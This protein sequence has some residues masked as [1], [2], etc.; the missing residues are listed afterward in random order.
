MG[1]HNLPELGPMLLPG[2]N[3]YGVEFIDLGRKAA[4]THAHTLDIAYGPDPF[5]AL[6]VWHA[7]ALDGPK[8][9]VVVFIHGGAFR[10]G[11]KEWIGAMAPAITALPAVLVSFNYRLVPRVTVSSI[12]DDCFE[13][14][15]W[16]HNNIALF[17]GD[18]SRIF[19]G[20]HSA[21]AFLAAMLVLRKDELTRRSILHESI[22]A[23]MPLSGLFSL[24]REDNSKDSIVARFWQEM[25]EDD[26]TA[27]ANSAVTY[28]LANKTPFYIAY[29]EDE[30]DEILNANAKMIERSRNI[31]LTD[32]WFIRKKGVQKNA[33]SATSMMQITM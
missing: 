28:A 2:A 27:E 6:D 12:V 8:L 15:A 21:G 19:I 26:A 31:S 24:R 4:E 11:H 9:P 13:A 30:P 17:G 23:C 25:V 14:L 5:Q 33:P 20:G 3:E 7:R 22:R 32:A 10:N 29:G 16:V 1:F 18:P